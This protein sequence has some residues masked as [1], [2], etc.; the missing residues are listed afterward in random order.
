MTSSAEVIVI[1]A[2]MA[3]L[4]AA[5]ELVGQGRSVIVLEAKDRVGG[6]TKAGEVAGRVVDAGGQWVGVGHETLL[7]EA[8]RLGIETYPQYD[9]GK[10]VMQ[11]L[12][13]LVN[14]SGEVPKMPLLGLLELASLQRRWNRDM[15]TLPAEAPWTAPRAAEWDAQTLESWILANLRTASARQFARL[16]PRGAWATEASQVSYL[17]F[18]DALRGRH[19]ARLLDGR[20]GRRPGC[21]VRRR[22]APDRPA[23]GRGTGRAGGARARRCARWRRTPTACG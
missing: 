20:Q 4:K 16:V 19:G 14:F 5:Q 6:R 9:Q 17:W 15:K 1:G 11:L 22:H 18:L 10:T 13:K 3:G 2:G 12:G 23:H 8:R 21:E 7:A